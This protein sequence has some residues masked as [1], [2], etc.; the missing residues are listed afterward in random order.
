MSE[1]AAGL[2]K[3]I[4]DILDECRRKLMEHCQS[5]VIFVTYENEGEAADH[6]LTAGNPHAVEGQV[7][8]WLVAQR[9]QIKI[10]EWDAAYEDFD[11][12]DDEGEDPP[13]KE[14]A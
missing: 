2:D 3:I 7:R 1:D 5:V 9:E 13:P 8:A 14:D 6:F 4:D 10:R 11:D 12:D